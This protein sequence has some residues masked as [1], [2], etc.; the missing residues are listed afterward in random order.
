MI[1]QMK[2]KLLS[3]ASVAAVAALAGANSA[4]ATVM[5]LGPSISPSP[6]LT[7]TAVQG[8][9]ASNPFG[10]GG[11]PQV[12]QNFEFA[13]S[14]G[15]AYTGG[16]G[17]GKGGKGGGTAGLTN[18]GLG[19]YTS[20][21]GTVESTGLKATFSAPVAASS[22]TITV[23]DF[24]IQ[25]V[26]GGF[27][28]A[29]VEPNISIFGANGALIGTATP[30]QVLANMQAAAGADK[31]DVWN[32]NVGGLLKTM[33][34]SDTTI[35]GYLLSADSSNGERTNSDPYLL[36]SAGAGIPSVPETST[37]L[38]LL[39]VLGLIIGAPIARRRFTR[40]AQ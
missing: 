11:A 39:G 37:V 29:K 40:L 30:S 14:T 7:I 17:G 4:H 10:Q 5:D 6:G 8:I 15:V 1:L 22:V 20:S 28:T 31:G 24:D 19:L 26:A 32:V 35:S 16:S 36:V 12:N 13:G 2:L 21:G 33:G 27:R 34:K 25:S 23:E 38:P 3:F 18:F 9:D